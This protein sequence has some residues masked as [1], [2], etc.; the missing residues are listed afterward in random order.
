MR[1]V[2]L[3][4]PFR[5]ANYREFDRNQRY[6]REAMRDSLMRGEAPFASHRLYTGCLD[7]D[8]LE[9]RKL[10]IDAGLDWGAMAEATVVYTDL[11]V[12]PGMQIGIERA[13]AEGR[14]VDEFRYLPGW[15]GKD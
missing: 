5:G 4:S 11:G 8:I 6:L 9:E 15:E 2:I 13:R 3:E 10:G 1:R 14:P 7:D 12:S